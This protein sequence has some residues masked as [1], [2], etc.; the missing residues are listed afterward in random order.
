MHPPLMCLCL[1]YYSAPIGSTRADVGRAKQTTL[2]YNATNV[3]MFGPSY[4]ALRFNMSLNTF[5]FAAV[6]VSISY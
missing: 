3:D 5:I 1:S 4:I 6:V 2:E